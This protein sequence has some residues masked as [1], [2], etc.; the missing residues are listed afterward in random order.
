MRFLNTF[1][2][3]ARLLVRRRTAKRD[4]DDEMRFHLDVASVEAIRT[5]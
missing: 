4:M 1:L 3:R 2:R 5:D